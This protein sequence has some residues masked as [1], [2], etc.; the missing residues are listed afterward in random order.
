MVLEFVVFNCDLGLNG[1]AVSCELLAMSL[2]VIYEAFSNACD[3][4]PAV[5]LIY[6]FVTSV[7]GKTCKL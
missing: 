6:W 3:S 2:F 5:T 1:K 4:L 7:T